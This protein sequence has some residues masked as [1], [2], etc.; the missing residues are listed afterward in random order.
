MGFES[1]NVT[2]RIYEVEG[3][4]TA[5]L[6]EEFAKHVVPPIETLDR[7][8]ISGW[9]GPRHLLDREITQDNCLAGMYLRVAL[10]KAERKIPPSL[11][12]A[13]CR[14]EEQVEM[15]ARG[16]PFLNRI[17]RSEI[18]EEV[19]GRLLPA[20]P[21]SLSG[22]PVVLDLTR[23]DRLYAQAMSE[24]QQDAFVAGFRSATGLGVMPLAP[25]VAA[26]KLRQLNV[27]DFAPAIFAPGESSV[28]PVEGIGLDFLTWLWFFWEEKGG[29]F[30]ANPGDTGQP[31]QMML[32]GPLTFVVEGD[33]AHE[34]VLRRGMPLIS[35]EAK[36][37][38]LSGK[39]LVR[40]KMN[41]VRGDDVWSVS[42]D[43]G[44]FGFRSLKLPKLEPMLDQV[45]QYQERMR[46]LVTFCDAFMGLFGQFLDLRRDKAAWAE[47]LT[48]MQ[49]WISSRRALA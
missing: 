41:L 20:M 43:G 16:L 35:A 26:M 30:S 24:K 5:D 10:L 31:W 13:H 7:E 46:H 23:R 27:R 9:G 2:F 28:A 1:G 29:T 3:E 14:L 18:K 37:A 19:T 4:L 25:D 12:R 32:E 15:K 47:T 44:D 11:L 17:T 38:L 34:T 40:C 49:H 22:I 45:S 8:P 6:L 21:P 39:K 42:I 36:T 48:G 33:G